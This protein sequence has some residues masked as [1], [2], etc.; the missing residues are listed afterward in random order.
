MKLTYDTTTVE[1]DNL[2][3]GYQ[4][5][6]EMALY[7]SRV[8]TGKINNYDDGMNCDSFMCRGRVVLNAT[9]MAT[10]FTFYSD[11]G[12]GKEITLTETALTGFYPFTPALNEGTGF[13]VYLANVRNLGALDT[14]GKRFGVEITLLLAYEVETK[15]D[16]VGMRSD[17]SEGGLILGEGA[18]EVSGIRFPKGGFNPKKEYAVYPRITRG[19]AVYGTVYGAD[20]EATDTRMTITCTEKTV[21]N[22]LYRLIH[23]WRGTA[24]KMT[25]PAKHYPF[26]LDFGD[27][28]SFDVKLTSGDVLVR[29]T[30]FNEF[31]ITLDVNLIS[32]EAPVF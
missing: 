11:T 5:N 20:S 6:V 8:G 13:K 2:D 32:D 21:G 24:F 27:N 1:I 12:R 16:F 7:T 14:M 18:L 15:P 19:G 9:D 4:T 26:G 31:E 25:V 3:F 23:N 30:R 17:C 29:H 10:L 22:I 28:T